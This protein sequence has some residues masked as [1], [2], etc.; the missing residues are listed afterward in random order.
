MGFVLKTMWRWLWGQCGGGY[1]VNV[2]VAM[3][4]QTDLVLYAS[5]RSIKN[6]GSLGANCKFLF[7]TFMSILC[8]EPSNNV[9][10]PC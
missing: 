8:W 3:G 2:E 7:I 10:I 4:R 6:L 1:G 9:I 5:S